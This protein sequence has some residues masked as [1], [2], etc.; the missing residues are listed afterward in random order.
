MSRD[1]V[2]PIKSIF[3]GAMYL[4]LSLMVIGLVS[5]RGVVVY[6][7]QDKTA[8]EASRSQVFSSEQMAAQEAET[9]EHFRRWLEAERQASPRQQLD[10]FKAAS[11][12]LTWI[13]WLVF[14]WVF[15][16]WP[17]AHFLIAQ[18]PALFLWA[19]GLVWPVEVILMLLA[20]LVSA[21]ARRRVYEPLLQ[22]KR[23]GPG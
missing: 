23:R 20:A 6:T 7:H 8:L 19:V 21:A 2:F 15:C 12:Y 14:G 5:C 10:R 3:W 18:I 11:V 17:L 4:V 13:P 1:S 22:W 9:A 16:R